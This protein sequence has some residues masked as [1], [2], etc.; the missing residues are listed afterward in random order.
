M[1]AEQRKEL[2]TNTLADKMGN[3]MQRVKSSPRRTFFTYLIVFGVLAFAAWFG[4]QYYSE[5]RAGSSEQWVKI[6]DAAGNHIDELAG[7]EKETNAGK[8]ARFQIAW[9][10]YWDLGIKT[11][12]TDP[13]GSLKN[14][15]NA[16]GIYAL[17]A[18]ECKDDPL[19]EPQAMLGRAV[20][21]ESMAVQ[22]L[23]HLKKAKDHYEAVVDKYKDKD[24]AEAKFA[25][26]RLE[27]FGKNKKREL[28]GTYDMLQLLLRVPQPMPQFMPGGDGLPPLPPIKGKK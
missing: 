5:Q 11:L 13:T 26:Q 7:K 28:E 25:Q 12:A 20:V 1:K 14:L 15:K 16:G 10:L 2:E 18:E 27:S 17:L 4:W 22:N 9:L 3:V 21:E 6:Y 19:F 23:D 24:C 8:A